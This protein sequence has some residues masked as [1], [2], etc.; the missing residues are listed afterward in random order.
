MSEV[1]E[2]MVTWECQTTTE[3]DLAMG[4]DSI[5]HMWNASLRQAK[6]VENISFLKISET[7]SICHQANPRQIV[8]SYRCEM[9]YDG[10]SSDH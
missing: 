4:C 3:D 1:L 2:A 10:Y 6:L 8:D 9:Q 7:G 5:E